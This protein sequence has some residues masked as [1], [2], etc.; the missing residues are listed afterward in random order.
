MK[1]IESSRIK[2]KDINL[3]VRAASGAFC[4]AFWGGIQ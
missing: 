3:S 2:I 4:V 1:E